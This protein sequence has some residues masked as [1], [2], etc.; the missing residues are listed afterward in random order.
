[1]SAKA[2]SEVADQLFETGRVGMIDARAN[3]PTIVG[4]V[5][6]GGAATLTNKGEA[7]ARVVTH[8]DPL[9]GLLPVH[10]SLGLEHNPHLAVHETVEKYTEGIEDVWIND[11]ERGKAI[12]S[13]SFWE[14]H[15]HPESPVGSALLAAHSLGAL[16]DY[17]RTLED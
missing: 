4:H 1:M 8:D 3:L 6:A 7:V 5:D 12:R 14:L 16:L 15:W 2:A 10:A 17:A 9:T 13:G 11:D